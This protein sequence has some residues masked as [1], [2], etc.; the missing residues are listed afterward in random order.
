MTHTS[1]LAPTSPL[2]PGATLFLPRPLA[3]SIRGEGRARNEPRLGPSKTTH[4]APHRKADH[5]HQS[6]D[7]RPRCR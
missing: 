4:L 1:P 5:D 3:P 7:R 6:E 2:R